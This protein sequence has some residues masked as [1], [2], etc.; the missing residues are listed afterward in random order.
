MRTSIKVNNTE[1]T[2]VENIFAVTCEK[3]NGAELYIETADIH[4]H[5]TED[6]VFWLLTEHDTTPISIDFETMEFYML[7]APY[8]A[9]DFYGSKDGY[10]YVF[11]EAEKIGLS[12]AN[13][14]TWLSE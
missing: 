8:G 5:H 6:N 9:S 4:T 1:V 14:E 2:E 12:I 10:R 11:S 3:Y 7:D 13:K